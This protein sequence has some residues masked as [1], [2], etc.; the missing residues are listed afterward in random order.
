M[1][2]QNKKSGVKILYW[3]ELKK[4]KF[5]I[6]KTRATSCE[7]HR[8]P[9]MELAY[10]CGGEIEHT[11]NTETAVLHKG[12]YF[13][14]D[15]GSVHAY[16]GEDPAVINCVFYPEMIDS[17]LK[18]CSGIRDILNNY[19]IRF[20]Y[21]GITMFPTLQIYHD[22]TGE[23]LTLLE[24]MGDEYEGKSAGYMEM[25]RCYL[26]ETILITMRKSALRSNNEEDSLSSSII[27]MINDSYMQEVTLSGI[28]EKLNYSL[29]YISRKFKE[30]TGETFINYLHKVRMKESCRM[31]ANTDK[32]IEEISALVGYADVKYFRKLFKSTLKMTPKQFRKQ[33]LK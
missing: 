28:C 18:N 5:S 12:D 3:D 29:P 20:C 23:I 14:V 21:K 11:M 25:I 32:N 19:L 8:H 31:L 15:Y 2:E 26:V 22:D 16:K 1:R 9:F 13:I 10:I 17:T 33:L 27:Y 30:E 4:D 24:K 6:F 7:M